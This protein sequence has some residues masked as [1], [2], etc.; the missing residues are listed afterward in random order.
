[1]RDCQK[2][3]KLT[4]LISQLTEESSDSDGPSRVNPLQAINALVTK[5]PPSCR[6]LLY[7]P[8]MINGR[9]LKAMIDTGATD[10]FIAEELAKELQLQISTAA[11]MIKAIN[12]KATR[13]RGRTK[14]DLK[15]GPWHGPC[16]LMVIPLDDFQII[17]GLEFF[18]AAKVMILPHL[19]GML[20]GAEDCTGFVPAIAKE[21]SGPAAA[22]MQETARPSTGAAVEG[23]LIS[24]KQLN[25]G[26]RKGDQTY[27]AA[28]IQ[29]EKLEGC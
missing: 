21:S 6:G 24:A 12:S 19:N 5:K 11:T 15:V 4:A 16:S 9:E 26:L 23:G 25:K 27:V 3:G 18:K 10:N 29:V 13:V 2:K 7:V 17:L 22:A 28:L 14:A 20:I 1:M 8:V